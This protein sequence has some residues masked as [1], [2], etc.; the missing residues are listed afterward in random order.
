MR[1]ILVALVALAACGHSGSGA[2]TYNGHSYAIGDVFP[3]GDGCNSCTCTTS[4]VACTKRSCV[5]GGVIDAPANSCASSG[6]C[7]G[8]VCGALCCAQGER[9]VNGSCHC[10]S[11]NECPSGDMCAGPGPSG[12]DICGVLCCGATGPC[13]Q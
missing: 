10:G 6:G 2:C 7:P 12:G 8:P 9:C 11:G 1:W 3:Q 13:P 4:G 5:D